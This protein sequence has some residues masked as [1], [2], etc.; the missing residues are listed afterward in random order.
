MSY[1][2]VNTQLTFCWAVKA[3]GSPPLKSDFDIHLVTPSDAGTYTNDGVTTYIAPT[4]TQQ[5][6]VTFNFTPT[7]VGRHVVT[8]SVGTDAVFIVNAER[9]V[10]IVDPPA[11]VFASNP[12]LSQGPFVLPPDPPAPLGPYTFADIA[13]LDISGVSSAELSGNNGNG[14]LDWYS[15]FYYLDVGVPE[16]AVPSGWPGFGEFGSIREALEHAGPKHVLWTFLSAPAISG[17][18]EPYAM[19]DNDP[20]RGDDY[21]GTNLRHTFPGAI[22][23][24]MN[25]NISFSQGL[26]D[27]AN[28]RFMFSSESGGGSV[29]A[30]WDVTVNDNDRFGVALDARTIPTLPALSAG[31][32]EQGSNLAT[33]GTA[34]FR[35]KVA[36]LNSR[37]Y[38][39]GN[40][41]NIL[42]STN[43]G[44]T[45][46]DCFNLAGAFNFTQLAAGNGIVMAISST[47]E[48]FTSVDNGDNWVSQ[49]TPTDW[50]NVYTLQY[51]DQGI[52]QVFVASVFANGYKLF[53]STNGVSWTEFG[54]LIT[55]NVKKAYPVI[56]DV[57]NGKEIFL[58]YLTGE[59]TKLFILDSNETTYQ[60]PPSATSLRSIHVENGFTAFYDGTNGFIG[61]NGTTEYTQ[62]LAYDISVGIESAIKIGQNIIF[63]D[64]SNLAVYGTTSDWLSQDSVSIAKIPT[65]MDDFILGNRPVFDGVTYNFVMRNKLE[66]YRSDT[67]I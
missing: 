47:E 16:Q 43:N 67:G 42:R 24:A 22:T 41:G 60:S 64:S 50:T 35:Y 54:E 8:L 28:L 37:L 6:Q 33:A 31:W 46:S 65:A 25:F 38:V 30:D 59:I 62:T 15:T 5:G 57:G 11:H 17:E 55:S 48:V 2:I 10:Y 56:N 23:Y 49:G 27:P 4:A 53:Y 52:Y 9:K 34:A 20:S 21:F 36:S 13:Y 1:F 32:T 12:K 14:V 19:L 29:P 3:T 7:V 44:T 58:Y 66:V 26:Q 51:L 63:Y 61:Y 18:P 45:F 40:D 39:S